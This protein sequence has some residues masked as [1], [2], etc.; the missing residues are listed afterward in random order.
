V[1][2]KKHENK[3]I[4]ALCKESAGIKTS[5]HG[6]GKMAKLKRKGAELLPHVGGRK[7]FA[8][9]KEKLGQKEKETAKGGGSRR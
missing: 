4:S 5:R 6:D 9:G 3:E 7:I 2:A 8:S 1:R